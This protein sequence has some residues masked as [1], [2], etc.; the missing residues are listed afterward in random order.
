MALRPHRSKEPVNP[1]QPRKSLEATKKLARLIREYLEQFDDRGDS[2]F[3]RGIEL[4]AYPS[5][6]VIAPME[7]DPREVAERLGR[8]RS[9]LAEATEAAVESARFTREVMEEFGMHPPEAENRIAAME[10]IANV[11]EHLMGEYQGI[12]WHPE[13]F[14]RVKELYAQFRPGDP[15]IPITVTV[16]I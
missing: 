14:L 11:L 2:L 12:V 5:P 10:H 9:V 7:M 3:V 4:K 13:C 1:G 15:A 16:L 6:R 8:T